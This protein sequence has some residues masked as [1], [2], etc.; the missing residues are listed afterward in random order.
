MRIVMSLIC[1]AVSVPLRAERTTALSTPFAF[2]A[3]GV[4][5]KICMRQVDRDVVRIRQFD[6]SM[7]VQWSFPARKGRAEL[8]VFRTSGA[9]VASASIDSRHGSAAVD[10]PVRAAVAGMY[11][12]V[13]RDQRGE[14]NR[15]LFMM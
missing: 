2:P 3:A 6:R 15:K 7:R 12:V 14:F 11:L 1:I 5:A 9:L 4:T 13:F 8:L 10:L